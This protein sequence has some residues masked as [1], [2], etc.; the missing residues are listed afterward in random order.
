MIMVARDMAKG[1]AVL[2]KNGIVH[3][4]LKPANVLLKR[5]PDGK[6][7][8]GVADF[9]MAWFYGV[10]PKERKKELNYEPV[11]GSPAFLPPEYHLNRG[12]GPETDVWA[13]GS[14]MY[15]MWK[16][17]DSPPVFSVTGRF[18]GFEAAQM[19]NQIEEEISKA[20]PGPMKEYLEIMLSAF[21]LDQGTRPSAIVIQTKL[22]ALIAKYPNFFK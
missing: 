3:N 21:T 13:M 14:I 11:G 5:M 8:A 7:K 10:N 20:K 15:C 18:S 12:M 1:T 9:G 2:H 4:D 6:I 16:K 22:D 19:R 17:V